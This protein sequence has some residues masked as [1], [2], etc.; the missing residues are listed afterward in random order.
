MIEKPVPAV[1]KRLLLGWLLRLQRPPSQHMLQDHVDDLRAEAAPHVSRHPPQPAVLE[2]RKRPNKLRH[3]PAVVAACA[4]KR[5]RRPSARQCAVAAKALEAA[6][7]VEVRIEGRD[8]AA[9]V[10]LGSLIV[11][12]ALP[13]A[14]LRK[15]AGLE[16]G[17][18]GVVRPLGQA[19]SFVVLALLGAAAAGAE[20]EGAVLD[21]A[22]H[23]A[24]C[25]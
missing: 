16:T 14:G 6:Q 25:A 23:D 19:G 4:G 5:G 18:Y 1:S 15:V 8:L 21:R 2:R 12:G 20:L 11:E 24:M 22:G 10:V 3:A 9:D 13:S 7:E 17:C